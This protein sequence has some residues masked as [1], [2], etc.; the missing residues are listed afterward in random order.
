MEK[1]IML[2]TYK[3]M[4]IIN[5]NEILYCESSNNYTTFYLI[6][7][8]ELVVSKS[9]NNY[10]HMLDD[11][12]FYR[13]HSSILVNL[14]YIKSYVK[15]RGGYVIMENGTELDVSIRK[16]HQFLQILEK[17]MLGVC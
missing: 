2:S 4:R 16:K 3:E 7:G 13:I 10:N 1:R 12:D 8:S 14:K 15:G 17:N 6:D 5:I 11:Y 9:L